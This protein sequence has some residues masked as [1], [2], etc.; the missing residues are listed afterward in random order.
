VPKRLARYFDPISFV[1]VYPQQQ[2]F[3]NETLTLER[4]ADG[5]TEKT[6]HE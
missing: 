4:S 1:I 3:L 2:S 6:M 5:E